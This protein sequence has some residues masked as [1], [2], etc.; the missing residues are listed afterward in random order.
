M[1]E[2]YKRLHVATQQYEE[3]LRE[4]RTRQE[5]IIKLRDLC[6]VQE[7]K[8][9]ELDKELRTL[10]TLHQEKDYFARETFDQVKDL[11]KQLDG[12]LSNIEDQRKVQEMRGSDATDAIPCHGEGY[13]ALSSLREEVENVKK[14]INY[15]LNELSNL[16]QQVAERG[17]ITSDHLSHKKIRERAEKAE[18]QLK[19]QIGRASC[20]ERV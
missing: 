16:R 10:K 13:K 9:E 17:E 8:I 3:Q 1:N 4:N 2:G 19:K 20:R 14:V 6:E 15:K 18:S 12:E 7:D 5:E 11:R